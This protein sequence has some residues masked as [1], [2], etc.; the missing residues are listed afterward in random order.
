MIIENIQYWRVGLHHTSSHYSATWG[1]V[2][3]QWSL[4]TYNNG[5]GL[6]LPAQ[7]HIANIVTVL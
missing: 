5:V 1:G 2:V 6:Q 3:L 4:K 7:L